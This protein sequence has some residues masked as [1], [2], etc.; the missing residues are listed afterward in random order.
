[1]NATRVMFRH[2]SSVLKPDPDIITR[3]GARLYE[4]DDVPDNVAIPYI[5][6]AVVSPGRM[7]S[8]VGDEVIWADV[9]TQVTAWMVGNDLGVIA[10]ISGR[11]YTKLH[12]SSG[13]VAGLGEVLWCSA[14]MEV[15]PPGAPSQTTGKFMRQGGYEFRGRVKVT[16][17]TT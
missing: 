9:L 1:M 2:F 12:R 7:V 4:F 8:V 17:F 14:E 15:L 13:V 16:G 11:I 10:P 3:V 6:W 5:T